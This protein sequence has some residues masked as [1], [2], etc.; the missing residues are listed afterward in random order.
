MN[1]TTSP[2]SKQSFTDFDFTQALGVTKQEMLLLSEDELRALL[3]R[4]Q[5]LRTN[6]AE[7][8]SSRKETQHKVLG[9]TSSK[10]KVQ[11]LG[12]LL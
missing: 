12:D 10:V 2:K 1:Q 5:Q 8:R 3:I 4:I 11:G 6:P 7:R 9:T